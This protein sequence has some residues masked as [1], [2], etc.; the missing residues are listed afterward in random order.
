MLASPSGLFK[1]GDLSLNLVLTMSSGI[2]NQQSMVM[3]NK[4]V[5][6]RRLRLMALSVPSFKNS[7][8]Q[9]ADVRRRLS[10]DYIDGDE[11]HCATR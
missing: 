1:L 4:A 11:S 9:R 7:E 2:V 10:D 6:E 3:A 5:L 8:K